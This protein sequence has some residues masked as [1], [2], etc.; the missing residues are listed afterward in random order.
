MHYEGG[1][2]KRA[3]EIG[4]KKEAC[5]K[6]EARKAVPVVL[7]CAVANHGLVKKFVLLCKV[8]SIL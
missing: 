1:V 6:A 2:Y 8:K 7:G 5:Q 4:T 3:Q